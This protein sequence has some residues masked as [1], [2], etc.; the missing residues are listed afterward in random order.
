MLEISL[1]ELKKIVKL[2]VLKA[3]KACLKRDY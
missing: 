2:E 1:H 3:K